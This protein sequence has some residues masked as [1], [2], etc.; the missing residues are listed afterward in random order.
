MHSGGTPIF[1][2]TLWPFSYYNTR[3]ALAALP[4]LAIAGAGV[5]LLAP[6]RSRPWIA[7]AILLAA[8]TPWLLRPQP[9]DWVTWKE[10]QRNSITATRLDQGRCVLTGRRLSFWTRAF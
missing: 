10:S 2:P 1:V 5:V 7:A 4:L 3:Y 8:A 9:G 6:P